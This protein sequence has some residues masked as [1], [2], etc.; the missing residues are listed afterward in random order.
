MKPGRQLPLTVVRALV[1]AVAVGLLAVTLLA[2]H[3]RGIRA[4]DR[5]MLAIGAEDVARR[6][7]ATT[8]SLATVTEMGNAA[9]AAKARALAR[10]VEG[11]PSLV[12]DHARFAALAGTLDVD[13]LHVSDERGILVQSLPESFI[14][15]DMD[16]ADQPRPFMAAITNRSFVYVQEPTVKAMDGELF[17]YAGVARLDRPGIVQVGQRASRV[18]EARKL[19]DVNGIASSAR[20]G[21]DGRV[22]IVPLS[23]TRHAAL[24]M[25]VERAYGW[26]SY[27]FSSDVGGY[28]VVASTPVR[29]PWFADDVPFD[30]LCVVDAL[31]VLLALL[32]TVPA[33]RRTALGHLRALGVLFVGEEGARSRPASGGPVRRMLRSPLAA[34]CAAFF[35]VATAVAWYVNSRSA[36]RQ[37]RELLLAAAA[38]VRGAVADCVDAPLFFL[39][40]AICK[41]YGSPEAMPQ[42]IVNEVMRRYDIDELNVI[43]GHGVIIAG[44]LADIGYRMDSNP[45]SAEFNRLLDGA[46]TFSQ[47]F[48]GAIEDPSLRRKYVGVAFP[49][50]AR[51]YVQMGFSED[52]VKDG[53][54]YWFGNLAVGR[55]V[56]ETGFYVVAKAETGEIDSCGRTLPAGADTLAAIGFDVAAAPKDPQ[57]FFEATLCGEPCLCL[58]ESVSFHRILTALPLAEISGG[59]IRS[60]LA[61]MTILLAALTVAL[62]FL[63]RLSDLVSS[64]KGYIAAER[65]Q[66]RKEMALAHVVQASS[67]PTAFPD[68]AAYRIF[69]RMDAAKNVGGDFYDFYA[70]PSG[71]VAFLVADVSGKGISAAMFMMKAKAIVKACAVATSDLAAAVAEANR[72]LS[73]RNE[74]EMFVTAFI[75]AIDLATGE[76]EYVNAGHNPPLVRRADGT[77]EWVR[78]HPSLVLAAM[79]GV[80][81]RSRRLAL[82]P[83]D[84]LLLYTDGVTEA[85]NVAGELY[86]EARLERALGRA[87][88]SF[89]SDIRA[90]VSGF[91]RGAEQS[92][93]ITMLS[94]EYRGAPADAGGREG[95]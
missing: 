7:R 85:M 63:T 2:V 90:D 28:R 55:H 49:P 27:V 51:G 83:G 61:T 34:A 66:Q 74:A 58:A 21:R 44:A 22:A 15:F 47:P 56:G 12:A 42:S 45:K 87:G 88:A 95:A 69:A 30:V 36:N 82:A 8:A 13:E 24:G 78:A 71:R 70:L 35:L 11:D 37:A 73:S 68:T 75:A 64:L 46:S 31:L 60:V 3:Y 48:R 39:G 67:L 77:V 79:P 19:A 54:D 57:T 41:N 6:V 5:S 10:I 76:V 26:R 84:A 80:A 14:G 25:T 40:N 92:D 38:D 18:R 62:V 81:Y 1:A 59:W 16:S 20:I 17:Q 43:D 23:E 32:L 86:G 72:R 33:C 50:P 94:F 91:V 29:G 4:G 93:D 52:R 65:E 53:L 89:V 9:L